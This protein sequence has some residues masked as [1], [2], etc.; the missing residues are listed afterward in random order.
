MPRAPLPTIG[1]NEASGSGVSPRAARI[2]SLGLIALVL[3]CL[4][5]KLLLAPL[6][7][8]GSWLA[9][10][11]VPLAWVWFSLARGRRKA[12]QAASLILPLFA[13]EGIV[14]AIAAAAPVLA[15][16]R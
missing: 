6:R 5:W 1:R 12:R 9:L 7:P 3:F 11:A 13:A 16:P 2:A 8:G 15:A 10:K 14:R 4:L